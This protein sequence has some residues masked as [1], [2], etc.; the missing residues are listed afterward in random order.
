[1]VCYQRVLTQNN[2]GQPDG[3]TVVTGVTCDSS[4]SYGGVGL[5][6]PGNPTIKANE[7]LLL[8]T[9]GV[10]SQ[11]T[12]YRVVSAGYDTGTDQTYVNLVG[13][14]WYG[15]G[16]GGTAAVVIIPGVT[17]VYTTTVQLWQ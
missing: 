14:D 12:W 11:Y 1:M 16:G 4:P 6:I 10:N 8:Y 2:P 3:E 17:G 13:P 9:G 15:G 7:W 5:T